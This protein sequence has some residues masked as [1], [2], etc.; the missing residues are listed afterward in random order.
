MIR[1]KYAGGLKDLDGFSHVILL[2]HLHKAGSPLLTVKP[3]MDDVPRGSLRPG[4]HA[5]KMPSA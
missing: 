5:A 4:I 1:R 2:Y 3:F